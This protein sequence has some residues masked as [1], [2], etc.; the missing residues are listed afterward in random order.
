M[1]N[2]TEFARV[3]NLIADTRRQCYKTV[4]N[5]SL[6]VGQNKLYCLLFNLVSSL[7]IHNYGTSL[8]KSKSQCCCSLYYRHYDD[9]WMTPEIVYAGRLYHKQDF[10]HI[11][12]LCKPT[13]SLESSIMHLE[14]RHYLERHSRGIIYHRDVF[15]IQ[16]T[17]CFGLSSVSNKKVL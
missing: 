16:A 17:D 9:K 8:K 14:W 11:W 12:W 15:I 6:T 4:F 1:G 13:T 10:D 5:S 7:L 3:Y 2:F